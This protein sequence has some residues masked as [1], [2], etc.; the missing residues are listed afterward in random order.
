MHCTDTVPS[1]VSAAEG[2]TVLTSISN[3]LSASPAAADSLL[4]VGGH[5]ALV[6]QLSSPAAAAEK[7]RQR[8][9]DTHGQLAEAVSVVAASNV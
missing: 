5:M 3:I 7:V 6:T 8:Q 1:S 2:Q 9:V 4:Q